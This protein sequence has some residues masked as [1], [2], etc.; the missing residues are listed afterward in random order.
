MVRKK[1]T[2]AA[3]LDHEYPHQVLLRADDYRG[4]NYHNQTVQGFCIG[5]SHAPRGHSIYKGIT[6]SV[7]LNRPIRIK[8][9][10]DL[11]ASCLT[12][13]GAGGASSGT[14]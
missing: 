4:S 12:L 11:A 1:E 10:R 14:C 6:C 13:R 5:L 7:F 8:S 3:R 9:A 2:V